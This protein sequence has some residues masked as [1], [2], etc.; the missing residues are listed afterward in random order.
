MISMNFTAVTPASLSARPLVPSTPVWRNAC[1]RPSCS[2]RRRKVDAVSR[3]LDVVALPGY[4]RPLVRVA[5]YVGLVEATMF[6]DDR[7]RRG[8]LP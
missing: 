4:S 1:E 2:S 8:S 5:D 6:R 3:A 7:V